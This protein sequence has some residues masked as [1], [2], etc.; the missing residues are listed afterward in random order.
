MKLLPEH[1]KFGELHFDELAD[2]READEEKFSLYKIIFEYLG[3]TFTSMRKRLDGDTH[4][5]TL[6]AMLAMTEHDCCDEDHDDATEVRV[7]QSKKRKKSMKKPMSKPKNSNAA[8]IYCGNLSIKPS[9]IEYSVILKTRYKT[10]RGPLWVTLVN[11][12][13]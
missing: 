8:C 13:M 11:K 4:A 10:M 9:H 1:T 5:P 7:V 2:V 3:R 6:Q 12:P